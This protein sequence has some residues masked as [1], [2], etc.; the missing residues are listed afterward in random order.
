[1]TRL[2][3]EVIIDSPTTFEMWHHVV[4]A[5]DDSIVFV[6]GVADDNR[7][8]E[9]PAVYH[10]FH[11]DAAAVRKLFN[12]LAAEEPVRS[13][14]AFVYHATH[15]DCRLYVDLV[16]FDEGFLFETILVPAATGEEIS[17]VGRY[18][19]GGSNSDTGIYPMCE[20][21]LFSP[22]EASFYY[23]NQDTY[24]YTDD[25]GAQCDQC[26]LPRAVDVYPTIKDT[27]CSGRPL[28]MLVSIVD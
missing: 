10:T 12:D 2:Q 7:K 20:I 8:H 19:P 15:G 3:G 1:M 22:L 18:R 4:D 5:L 17:L 25:T 9:G 23:L 6:D 26:W 14:P 24:F 11:F 13:E 16:V 27:L 21:L 28:T